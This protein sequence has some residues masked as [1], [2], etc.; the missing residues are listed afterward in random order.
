MADIQT[1][2]SIDIQQAK[3]ALS[4]L[5]QDGT[6]WSA[7]MSKKLTANVDL[8]FPEMSQ[9][10]RQFDKYQKAVRSA[11]KKIGGD[12]WDFQFYTKGGKEQKEFN[13]N[14]VFDRLRSSK[15]DQ[16]SA[17]NYLKQL[18][19]LKKRLQAGTAISYGNFGIAETTQ[20]DKLIEKLQKA[21]GAYNELQRTKSKNDTISTT[22]AAKREAR[23]ANEL[24]AAQ[25]K[26]LN[27]QRQIAKERA[28]NSK[29][30]GQVVASIY[31]QINLYH[32]L[33]VAAKKAGNAQLIAYSRNQIVALNKQFN[34]LGGL[35]SAYRQQG[36]I[37]RGL[38]GLAARYFSIYT[39]ANFARKVA[40]TTGY[41][42]QQQVALEGIL[43]SASAAREVLGDIKAFA[44]QSPFQTKELV[45][46]TKQLSA[47]GLKKNELF[48]TVKSLAD[49]SAGLGV[50]MSRIILAYGQVK[51]AAV[52][53]GQ[54]L[55]QFTEAGIPMVD[56]LAKKF[57]DLNGKLVTTGEVFKLISERRVPFEMVA[58]VLNDMTNEGGQFY[59]MQENL[60]DTLYGQ[61]QKLR[62]MW[63]LAMDRIGKGADGFIIKV[64]KGLQMLIEH[65]KELTHALLGAFIV[66]RIAKFKNHTEG[67]V[68]LM[69][70]LVKTTGLWGAVLTVATGVLVGVIGSLIEKHRRLK[71]AMDEVADGYSKDTKKMED[72]LDSL[73]KKITSANVGTKKFADAVSTLAS[74]YRDF[75]SPEFISALQGQGKEAEKAADAFMEYAEA[76]KEAIRQQ[77]NYLSLVGQGDVAAEEASKNTKQLMEKG[78]HW[79]GG[80]DILQRGY[81]KSTNGGLADLRDIS[82]V[83]QFLNTNKLTRDAFIS[84]LQTIAG[85]ALVDAANEGISLDDKE[86]L[87]KKF[88]K[89]I[90]DT[91]R[92]FNEE[93]ALEIAENIRLAID[94]K[95]YKEALNSYTGAKSTTYYKIDKPFQDAAK[96]IQ[97]GNYTKTF[98]N[99]IDDKISKEQDTAGIW[100]DALKLSLENAKLSGYANSNLEKVV[101]DTSKS[102]YDISIE[103]ENFKKG[104]NATEL[105]MLNRVYK[106]FSENMPVRSGHSLRIA[107]AFAEQGG[108]F[109]DWRKNENLKNIVS[110]Y[111]T[112]TDSDF[113]QKRND[114]QKHITY[115]PR[116]R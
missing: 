93:T 113:E 97:N 44:L 7:A 86:G 101:N 116:Q 6:K 17:L 50:D 28:Y 64:V 104:L 25:R 95:S 31:R 46:F 76:I 110:S 38:T 96:D 115:N 18:E 23:A 106:N 88:A 11:V 70:I 66:S 10:V 3:K 55:R 26:V 74:N 56:R 77:N 43:G 21:T 45:Q 5:L 42:Q 78:F 12:A 35:T 75:V 39:I 29:N 99:V 82:G 8:V 100:R 69:R 73:S 52:L 114:L 9:V 22:N 54:E 15:L 40:E 112:P 103:F 102:A 111:G 19:E 4:E 60:T 105:S 80:L 72:G 51:S 20:L 14:E 59:K 94:K 92:D 91:W 58:S 37:F 16:A 57:T 30:G 61:L 48:P 2:I 84:M 87:R 79:G 67:L 47:F 81:K 49:I 107:N 65:G 89:S 71:R 53:R 1:S 34:A 41:F 98:G 32:D 109:Y 27:I 24:E 62:D 90:T 68:R 33:E 108:L 85:T 13:F 36:D 83:S 63:T